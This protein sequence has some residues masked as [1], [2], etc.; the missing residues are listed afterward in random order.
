MIGQQ[1][2]QF[3]ITEKLGA[4]GMGEVFIA[5]DT[6]LH[7]KVAL[8]FLPPH[9]SG[10]PEFK[11]RFQHEAIAAASLN[12]PNIITVYDL[13]EHE[14]RLFIVLELVEGQSLEGLIRSGGLTVAKTVEIIL[15][16]CDGLRVA[17]EAG[18]V[19]RDIKPANILIDRNGR[20]KI[21]DFGLAKSR[22]ATTETRVGTTVGTIQ[23]ES[24]EQGRGEPVDQ[25][26]DLFSVGVLLY[27]MLTGHLPFKGEFDDAIRYAIANEEPEPL[28][29]YK[30]GVPDELQRI[31]T[32]LLEKDPELRYQTA[33]GV[34]PDLKLLQRTSGPRPSGIRSGV[35]SVPPQAAPSAVQSAPPPPSA[36]SPIAPRK[37]RLLPILV[38]STVA[39]IAVVLALVFKP[40]KIEVSP[41]QEAQASE[42]R[43][44]VMYFDNLAHPEDPQRLGEMVTDLLITTLSETRSL[45]VLS[46]QRLY[47]ILK[48]LGKEGQKSID[49]ETSSQVARQANARWMLTGTILQTE[50]RLVITA[51]VIDVASGQIEASQRVVAEEGEEIFAQVDRMASG[52]RGQVL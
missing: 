6:R 1:I 49:R 40:W 15:Q 41:T 27:E 50:P 8:K 42:D 46:S 29:R 44:A 24:P 43:L 4:G 48:Q 3:K 5:E 28:A 47:D 21:L 38:P 37:R 10:D 20:V 12:H 11:A 19:H 34:L 30:A 45:K 36:P 17:H 22:R 23:Y 51:Q 7:R 25:R 14:G 9:Y 16:V 31:V 13:G 2:H 33:S 18:I 52:I 32:K 39:V 35:S 26:S